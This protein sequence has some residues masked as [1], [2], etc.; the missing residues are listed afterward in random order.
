MPVKPSPP[1]LE[2]HPAGRRW[3]FEIRKDSVTVGRDPENDLVISAE[4]SGWETVSR[5][6]ARLY[7]RG[8]RWVV[9]DLASRNGIYVNGRRTGRNLLRDGWRLGIG[10]VEFIFHS[11]TGEVPQ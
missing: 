11:G 10:G 1:W 5:K 9:E 2:A 6:H 3:R 4:F 8:G 7:R